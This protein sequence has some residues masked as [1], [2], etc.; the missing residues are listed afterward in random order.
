MRLAHSGLAALDIRLLPCS[1]DTNY[2]AEE[3]VIVTPDQGT[4]LHR[5][6][7]AR[8]ERVMLVLPALVVRRR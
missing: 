2:R 1:S 8:G 6:D 3:A 5:V 4:A 7:L